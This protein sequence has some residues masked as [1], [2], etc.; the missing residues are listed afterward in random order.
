MKLTESPTLNT[1]Q[2]I[3][4][5][6]TSQ[7]QLELKTAAPEPETVEAIVTTPAATVTTGKT[8]RFRPSKKQLVIGAIGLGLLCVAGIFGL[9]W[10]QFAAIHEETDNATVIGDIYPISTRVNG[11]IARVLVTDNQQVKAGQTLIQ[12]DPRD[13]ESKVTQAQAA[14][15]TAKRQAATTRSNIQLAAQNAAASSTQAQGGV[16]NSTAGISSSQAALAEAQSGVPIAQAAVVQAQSAITT[17]L[18]AVKETQ[19]TIPAAQASLA[20]ATAGVSAAQSQV[21]QIDANLIKAKADYQRY[22]ELQKA[23]AAPQQQLDSARATYQAAVAQRSAA[24]QAVQQAKSRVAQAQESIVSARAKLAQS[25][26]GVARAKSQL[27]QAQAGVLQAK[28]RVA[29]AQEGVNRAKAQLT[30][31]QGSVQQARAANIQTDV[32]KSQYQ[33]ALA[34]VAQAEATLKDARLQLSYTKIVAPNDGRIGNKRVEVGQQAASGTPLLSIVANNPWVVA[35]FKET[36]L[37]KMQPGQT[38]EVKIDALA[39]HSFIGRLQSVSPASGARFSLLPPDNATG[40][41]TKIVQRIPVKVVFDPQS[42]KGYETR[43]APGMSATVTVDLSQ[44]RS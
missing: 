17:A 44:S 36:Q 29:Q 27:A 9:R 10:W 2:Q 3:P 26:E 39:K 24:V 38:V 8:D 23:G 20:E 43:I 18:A 12:L 32:N 28:S 33:A 37:S 1:Q 14:L 6:A 22:Q 16:S 25:Q 15:E 13:S 21:G 34:N 42:I 7:R 40:N 4:P 41:F 35:N 30:T 11:N 31:S 19:S 5:T